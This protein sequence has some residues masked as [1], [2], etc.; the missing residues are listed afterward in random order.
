MRVHHLFL[1]FLSSSPI[2][3]SPLLLIFTLNLNNHSHRR[4]AIFSFLLFFYFFFNNLHLL[5]EILDSC[6]H[7]FGCF[8]IST[9][10]VFVS[11]FLECSVCF[12]KFW[13]ILFCYFGPLIMIQLMYWE[14]WE[15]GFESGTVVIISKAHLAQRKRKIV[16]YIGT[17]APRPKLA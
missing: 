3:S 16:Q 4:I 11:L 8:Y 1:L 15:A 17:S 6:M 13:C 12:N 9:F 10:G 7:P 2:S 5:S 14:M